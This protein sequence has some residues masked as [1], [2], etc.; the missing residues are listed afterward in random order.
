MTKNLYLIC[1]LLKKF[2]LIFLGIFLQY[3]TYFC[4]ISLKNTNINLKIE[5][6]S[7]D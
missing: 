5:N 4:T 3:S 6:K 7:S 2:N 1:V